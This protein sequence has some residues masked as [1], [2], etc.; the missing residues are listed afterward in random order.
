MSEGR[1]KVS[2]FTAKGL[3]PCPV[4]TAEVDGEGSFKATCT[5]PRGKG[6]GIWVVTGRLLDEELSQGK[7]IRRLTSGKKGQ[8]VKNVR[9]VFAWEAK[10]ANPS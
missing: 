5:K 7:I 1:G 10:P 2:D 4:P 3:L 8:D 9:N 6:R